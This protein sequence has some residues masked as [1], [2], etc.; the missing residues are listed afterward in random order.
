M[1]TG[2]RAYGFSYNY[3]NG[4]LTAMT[5]PGGALSYSYDDLNRLSGRTATDGSSPLYTRSYSYLPGANGTTSSL[6][7]SVSN[8]SFGTYTYTYDAL[9]NILSVSGGENASYTYDAQGQLLTETRGGVTY[10]YTYDAAGNLLTKTR[11]G[12][13]GTDTYTYGDSDWLDLLT[14]YNG[15]PI[16]YDA[17]GNPTTWYDGATM[18]WVNGRRLESISATNA[19]A[20]LAFTYD[21]D[22]LRLTKTVGTGEN[23]MEHRYTWQ[24]S[25]LIAESYGDTALEFFYDESGKPFALLYGGDYYY[26][27]TNLQGDVMKLIDGS[28]TVVAEYSYDAWG[29]ILSATGTMAAINPLRYRGYYYDA[30]SG[31][32]Y[33]KSRY[34]DPAIGRF[35]NADALAS[36][37]QGILGTNMF[38][39]CNNGPVSREDSNGQTDGLATPYNS[40]YE[41]L[42]GAGILFVAIVG[43]ISLNTT[44][45]LPAPSL[46]IPHLKDSIQT[47]EDDKLLGKDIVVPTKQKKQVVFPNNPYRFNPIGLQ[48]V[49]RPGTKNGMIISWMD[50]N[51]I[52]VFRW[53]EN[54]NYSNGPHYHIYGQGHYTPGKDVVPEPFLTIYFPF[55]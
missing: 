51:N 54:L 37:G 46:T 32:Y 31:L 17:I 3:N 19:H 4:L 28:G 35:I 23:A 33:L 5:L 16:T 52:E 22:G 18:T 43:F 7:A 26:Y 8:G 53:D 20:A 41:K 40:T 1:D 21:G 38:A 44:L 9:G 13:S 6:V 42:I 49:V 25:K 36:T 2:S 45:D 12:G 55:G 29:N 50:S 15:S 30:E 10:T 34:Y 11:L 24:G 39:Y 48:M 27:L 47:D 14:A